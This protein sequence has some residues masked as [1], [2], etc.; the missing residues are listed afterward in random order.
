MIDIHSHIIPQADDGSK[1]IEET[2]NILK[3]AQDAGYTDIILTS[4]FIED[5]YELNKTDRQA[6][7]LALNEGIKKKDINI[8]LYPGAE[9]F[10]S[11]TMCENIKNGTICT[12]NNSRYVLFELPMNTK[13]VYLN[14]I[15]FELISMDLVPIIAHP[16]RYAF[17]QKD[18]NIL[19][20]YIEMGV[21]FQSNIASITGYYGNEAKKTVKK[22]LQSNMIH[23]F[24]S[25]NH[26]QNT[27]YANMNNIIEELK[28]V[29]TKQ[30]F[31]LLT[32]INPRKIINN[33]EIATEQPIR[34][35]ENFSKFFRRN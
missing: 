8:N 14:E 19:I 23:F 31:K 12:L 7:A 10:V 13:T 30:E 28:K 24:G 11:Q 1:S 6:W 3:E 9:I 22:L 27:I 18:P 32:E 20:D 25:D 26:R 21:L 29:I 33:E 2:F 4:H 17:V 16:E 35:K 5:H 34:I 15:I